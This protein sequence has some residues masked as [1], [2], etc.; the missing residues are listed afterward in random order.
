MAVIKRLYYLLFFCLGV[1]HA[2]IDSLVQF[3]KK[4]LES[5]EVDLLMSYYEQE[6]THAAVTG[7]LGNE[8]LT[9]YN[10]TVVVRIPM[11]EDAV[12]TADVGMS[13]CLLYTS[14]SP[15]DLSTSRMPSSA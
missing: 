3:K 5:V 9:D 14:P 1:A 6:G 10:P 4:V 2:Q 7:G 12:L 13:A 8:Y 15:R 11:N